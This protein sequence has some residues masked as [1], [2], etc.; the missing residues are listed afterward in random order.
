MGA[1]KPELHDVYSC[2]QVGRRSRS[3]GVH[4]GAPAWHGARY[5]DLDVED[6]DGDAKSHTYC[7]LLLGETPAYNPPEDKNGFAI[8]DT[9]QS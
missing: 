6:Y 2:S 9:I 8:L 5:R 7:V 3:T 4:S 1:T